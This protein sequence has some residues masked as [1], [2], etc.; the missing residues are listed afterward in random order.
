MS[1][2]IMYTQCLIGDVPMLLPTLILLEIGSLLACPSVWISDGD[3]CYYSST[4][5]VTH[6]EAQTACSGT[7]STLMVIENAAENSQASTLGGESSMWIGLEMVS[8]KN[9]IWVDG[10]PVSFEEWKSNGEKNGQRGGCVFIQPDGK[11]VQSS[12]CDTPM[13]F[14]CLRDVNTP[15]TDGVCDPA[16]ILY[17]LSE[18]T[19][20]HVTTQRT[21]TYMTTEPAQTTTHSTKQ[22]TTQATAQPTTQPTTQSTTQPTTKITTQSTT[23]TTMQPTELS[24][25][26]TTQPMPQPTS[27]RVTQPTTQTTT[28][29]TAQPT[30]ETAIQPTTQMTTQSTTKITTE[31]TTHSLTQSISQTTSHLITTTT[32]KT[33]QPS[34]LTSQMISLLNSTFTDSTQAQKETTISSVK[35]TSMNTASTLGSEMTGS[36]SEMNITLAPSI[37]TVEQNYATKPI[38]IYLITTKGQ[39]EAYKRAKR[40]EYEPVEATAAVTIGSIGLIIVLI[41]LIAVFIGDLGAFYQNFKTMQR[42]LFG[43][44]QEY[45]LQNVSHASLTTLN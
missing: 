25:Q 22:P 29:P 9:W 3:N 23:Q 11:W 37:A 15:C 36:T 18:T 24:T 32:E 33:S 42:N 14:I 10:T 1:T 17:P 5:L 2:R 31:A 45:Q 39:T 8:H 38:A 12:S 35:T 7:G 16:S 26:P 43:L 44:K 30:I 4:V 34:E 21:T 41:A 6:S 27:Q 28:Q 40:I 19:T 13:K 20:Q